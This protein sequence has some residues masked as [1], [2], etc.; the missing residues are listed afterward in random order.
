MN[1]NKEINLERLKKGLIKGDRVSIARALT[2]IEN[3]ENGGLL[4]IS[5]LIGYTGKA[6]V[7]GVTGPPGVGKSTLISRLIERYRKLG[8]RV[9]VLAIDPSS[10]ISGGAFL[11][12]RIRMLEHTADKG[13]YIRS[14]ASRGWQGGLSESA[15]KAVYL[16]DSA[17]IDVIIIETVGAGQTDIDVSLIS[18]IVVVVLMPNSGDII[19]LSKAGMM[20]VGDIFVVNK[21]DIQG[22]DKFVSSIISVLQNSKGKKDVFSVSST[23]GTGIEKLFEKLEMERN[24]L[25][26]K[27]KE[28]LKTEKTAI[29]LKMLA[30]KK[31]LE[32]LEE[33]ISLGVPEELAAKVV[34]GKIT[35]S[36]AVRI[37]SS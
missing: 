7:L 22:S 1:Q 27:G 34:S 20:E 13:V 2:L 23:T 37:L 24:A 25:K 21:A 9:G 30:R 17:G 35:L 3:D 36:R 19:Q 16:L 4:L 11:G 15:L 5:E 6:F 18:D 10:P 28:I 33:K 8:L 32:V 26:K 14:M 29:L 31:I 12:D